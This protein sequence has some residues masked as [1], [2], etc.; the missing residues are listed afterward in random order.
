[1]A[2]RKALIAMDGSEHS[3]YAFNWYMQN[4]HR[5]DDD[6]MLV[7]CA[8]Y[9][10]VSQNPV[11]LMSGIDPHM[12]A[13]MIQQEEKHV[14]VLLKKF[15]EMLQEAGVKG[16][17][18]RLAGKNPGEVIVQKANDEDVDFLVTGTRGLGRIRRTFVG[19][20]SDFILHHAH[21]PV[22]V[23]RHGKLDK[24]QTGH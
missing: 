15:H 7:F 2:N 20:V 12:L 1:M 3:E 21:M 6:V 14:A 22:F 23:C 10:S 4:L 9:H 8:E 24:H 16:Q 13:E 19:S 18:I 17:V 5:P 11:S